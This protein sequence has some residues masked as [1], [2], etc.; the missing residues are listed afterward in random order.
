MDRPQTSQPQ[1]RQQ[2]PDT[3]VR[4]GAW[5][6]KW[7]SVLPLPLA[8]LI[9][10]LP[11][12]SS[13][14]PVVL[15]GI[16]LAGLGEALRLAGVRHIGVVSRTR[17]DRSGPL[18]TTGPF[19]HVRNPLYLGNTALWTGFTLGAGLPWLAPFVLVL[20]GVEYHAIVRWEEALLD[21]RLGESYRAY[22][23]RVPRWVP[24]LTRA[25]A[26][27]GPESRAAK[28][29]WRDTLFS[30]R[31]TLVAVAVGVVLVWVKHR[32]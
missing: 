8:A 27:Q 19:A 7:R 13:S 20:L 5:L 22:A 26:A 12:H 2:D 10:L 18:V 9:V 28:F 29:S 23:A 6:F 15:V 3:V 11:A 32:L 16:L 4:F 24:R 31:G 25:R 17:I 1:S 21:S 30:E 14:P